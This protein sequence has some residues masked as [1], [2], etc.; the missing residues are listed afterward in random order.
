MSNWYKIENKANSKPTLW[1]YDE[2]GGY[3]IDARQFVDELNQLE[4]DEIDV[5]INSVGGEVFAGFAIYQALRDHSAKV[6]VFVDAIAASIASVISMAGDKVIMAESAQIMIHDGHVAIQGNAADLTRMIDTLD[7]TSNSIASVYA[8]RCGGT[9]ENWRE[10][11][12]AESWYN[13]EEA[14]AAGLADEIA[15]SPKR[16]TRNVADLR[17]FNYAGRDFA[18]APIINIADKAATEPVKD[19]ETVDTESQDDFDTESFLG[20]LKGAFDND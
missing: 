14:L 13:A 12:R 7:R 3:G 4:A 18:P 9:S 11:M 5:H 8:A 15:K 2:I 1:I 19:V 17:I 10:A 20:L 6:N 16:T